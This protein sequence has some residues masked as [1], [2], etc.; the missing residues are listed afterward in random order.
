WRRRRLLREGFR[1]ASHFSEDEWP[2][3]RSS[4]TRCDARRTAFALRKCKPCWARRGL[5]CS[6][7]GEVIVLTT[8]RMAA[9][10]PSYG[11]TANQRPVTRATY[12]SYWRRSND[13]HAP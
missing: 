13:D 3:G 10:L 6:T 12:A 4:S 7:R 2:A 11:L 8:A 5:C 1:A 9:C